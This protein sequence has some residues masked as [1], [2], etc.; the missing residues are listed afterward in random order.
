MPSAF[1]TI[2][3]LLFAICFG[4]VSVIS[5]KGPSYPQ[6]VDSI[7]FVITLPVKNKQ[8]DSL[9]TPLPR[10]WLAD[11]L[12]AIDTTI[13]YADAVKL[14]RKEIGGCGTKHLFDSYLVFYAD[15]KKAMKLFF[16]CRKYH[17]GLLDCAK[18][19][20]PFVVIFKP[21]FTHRL[22]QLSAHTASRSR[23]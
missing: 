16:S 13:Q 9:C 8:Q 11:Y 1:F 2:I 17:G 6:S 5:G 4:Q 14:H 3:V 15:K 22:E 18:D 21:G 7:R 23:H 10:T 20:Y 19:R 12:H